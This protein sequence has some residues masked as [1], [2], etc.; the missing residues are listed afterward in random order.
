MQKY[1]TGIETTTKDKTFLVL[2]SPSFTLFSKDQKREKRDKA[3]A[4][5]LTRSHVKKK[6]NLIKSY[7]EIFIF[8]F[9]SSGK[10][11]LIDGTVA[12]LTKYE[13]SFVPY[14]F[15]KLAQSS[16][17]FAD[18]TETSPSSWWIL[19]PELADV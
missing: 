11:R 14:E 9:D 2:K 7:D 16:T 4:S 18:E 15:D 19:A 1:E 10:S 8:L 12:K 6:K 5:T 17:S 13:A 3:E